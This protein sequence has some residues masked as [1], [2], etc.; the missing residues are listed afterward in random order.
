MY[1]HMIIIWVACICM[2]VY[3]YCIY[4]TCISLGRCD[5]IVVNLFIIE[6]GIY[7]EAD[8]QTLCLNTTYF[9]IILSKINTD[10]NRFLVG[11]HAEF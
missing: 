2:C 9:L 4:Y 11:L 3:R 6:L 7:N 5:V 1:A 8:S 10:Y